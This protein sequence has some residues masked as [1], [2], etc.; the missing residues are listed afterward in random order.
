MRFD[1]PH[2][3]SQLK[4]LDFR[5]L[6]AIENEMRTHEWVSFERIVPYVNA[7]PEHI[8][9]R[10]KHL[11]RW[12]VVEYARLSYDGYRL[13]YTGYDLLALNALVKRDSI[14]AVGGQVGFGKESDVFVVLKGDERR[15]LKLHRAGLSFKSVRR[16][17]R[18]IAERH[19]LSWVYASRLAAQREFDALRR[20]YPEV[21]VPKPID[22]NRHAILMELFEGLPLSECTLEQPIEC[23]EEVWHNIEQAYALGVVHAD[24]SEYN[25]LAS[26]QGVCIIDWPQWVEVGSEGADE[27]L[28]RDISNVC[29]HFT[30]KYGLKLDPRELLDRLQMK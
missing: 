14:D 15:I 3:Y 30:R 29:A 26:L 18:Y 9:H 16:T 11:R 2:L 5:I 4:P 17:R 22:H 8:A 10:L 27:L 12:K 1:A 7:S 24:L 19:H 20:L 25:I 13:F 23:F 28:E 6:T 21:N